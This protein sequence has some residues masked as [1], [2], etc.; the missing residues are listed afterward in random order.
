MVNKNKH[1]KKVKKGGVCKAIWLIS[2]F[3]MFCM[4][5]LGITPNSLSLPLSSFSLLFTLGFLLFPVQFNGWDPTAASSIHSVTC[6]VKILSP[7]T[8]KWYAFI[9][10]PPVP[11]SIYILPLYFQRALQSH[12]ID[13]PL[14]LQ[15]YWP[16]FADG[17]T[18]IKQVGRW[19]ARSW[20]AAPPMQSP[21]WCWP[22]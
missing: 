6:L 11:F 20:I 8:Q 4:Q 22:Q 17:G 9:S 10:V 2:V 21:V 18:V 15:Q 13:S 16:H 1:H 14:S 19:L 7:L 3:S 12:L 5:F